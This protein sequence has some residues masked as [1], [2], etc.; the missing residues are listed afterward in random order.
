VFCHPTP[1]GSQT[2]SAPYNAD[3]T[4]I[5]LGPIAG[6]PQPY[7]GLTFE[8]G[9]PN[10]LLIGGDANYAGG[11]L[12]TVDV[13]RGAGNHITGFSAP[14]LFASSPYIDG[15]VNYGPGGD[16]FTTGYPTNIINEFKPGSTSPDL[17]LNLTT[18][19]FNSSVGS[20]AFVPS[21][22]AG[23]GDFK[24][25]IYDTSDWYNVTLA[26]NPSKPGTYIISSYSLI[27]N[28][29]GG[30]YNLEGIAY[31]PPGSKLFPNPSVLIAEYYSGQIFTFQVD[32]NG[33]PI[34]ATEEPFLTGLIGAEGAVI[35]PLTGDFLF[36]TFSFSGANYIEEVKG[37]TTP[38]PVP[39]P[40]SLF[41]I[42]GGII[43][44][45]ASRRKFRK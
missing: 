21:G 7:G 29:S 17:T 23:A 19:G 30:T 3:Y 37:F 41:L 18:M 39:E 33:D 32:A 42:A 2:L 13:I 16:L 10:V 4:A 45:M 20:L 26:P 31:V 22:F 40:N 12:Y 44:L 34:L 24:V 9:N 11:A 28:L 8:A 25:A 36:S 43:G 14:T 15:G 1:A 38:P 35:D 27:E 5:D 6:L